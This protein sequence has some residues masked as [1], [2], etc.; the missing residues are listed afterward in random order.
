MAED[1][2][3][4]QFFP[5]SRATLIRLMAVQEINHHIYKNQIRQEI[6][7]M[8]NKQERTFSRPPR[9]I[10]KMLPVAIQHSMIPKKLSQTLG[11]TSKRGV[12]FFNNIP[13]LSKLKLKQNF[14]KC[15]ASIG[16]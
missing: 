13:K 2:L 3:G 4:M 15:Q 16:N 11:G 14:E 1:I 8:Q 10:S 6:L 12:A 7:P 5:I 9:E